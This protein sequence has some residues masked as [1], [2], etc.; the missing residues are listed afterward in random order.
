M[1]KDF[2]KKNYLY[3]QPVILVCTYDKD[4]VENIMTAAWG[5]MYDEHMVMICLATDHKTTANVKLH[6]EFVISFPTSKFAAEADYFGLV[7]GNKEINKV[8][9]TSL[10]LARSNNVYAPIILDL[11]LALECKAVSIEEVA[12][13]TTILIADIINTSADESVLKENGSIDTDLLDIIVY[14]P[15]SHTY[16]Q[17][18]KTVAKAFSSGRKFIKK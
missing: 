1:R 15:I 4:G 12:E 8:K 6:K 14:D 2:G 10:K 9:Y 11:P 7:S 16:R 3:P 17:I 18:G 13:G 5:G